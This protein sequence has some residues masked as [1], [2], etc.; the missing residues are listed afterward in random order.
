MIIRELVFGFLAPVLPLLLPAPKLKPE[1]ELLLKAAD[2]IDR[3]GLTKGTY[4]G[5]N[6]SPVCLVGSLVVARYGRCSLEMP[7][8][9]CV[10]DDLDPIFVAAVHRAIG[11]LMGRSSLYSIVLC[12]HWNDAG[13]RTKDEVVGLLRKAAE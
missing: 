9:Y 11:A 6:G 12:F 2:I 13:I 5:R 10:D 4:G 7:A 3:Q 8:N 1:E